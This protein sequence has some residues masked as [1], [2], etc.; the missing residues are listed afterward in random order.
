MRGLGR[1]LGSGAAI[2]LFLGGLAGAALA[3]TLPD[4][5]ALA[6]QSNPTLQSQRA[7]LRA[8]DESYVQARAGFRPQA[9]IQLQGD[10]ASGPSTFGAGVT[11]DAAAL[12]VSQPLYTGGLTS[13]QVRAAQADIQSGRQRLR[14]VEASVLQSVIQAYVDV[15]RD[16]QALGIARENVAVLLRQRD[17]TKARFDVGQI[18]RTDTAQADARLAA[19][20]AQLSA[21]QATLAISRAAYA[22]VVGQSP[23]DLAVE[24]ELSGLPPTVDQAFEGAEKDNPGVLLADYAEQAAAARVAAARSAYRPNVSLNASLGYE[25]SLTNAPLLGLRT[26]MYE[27]NITA[28]ATLTQP[29]FAGGMNASRI[30]EALENDNTQRLAVEGARRQAMQAIAQG[31]NQLLAA[32]GATTANQQQVKAD[33]IAFE[34]VRQ[35]AD[36]GLRTTLDVLN[37]EQELRNAQLALIDARHDQYVAAA[38]VLNAMGLLEIRNLD[39]NVPAYDPETSFRRVKRA[40]AVPWEGLVAGIDG[41]GAPR[42]QVR[43]ASA[44]VVL[45]PPESPAPAQAGSPVVE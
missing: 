11:T 23:G 32:R 44:P 2:G 28:A 21:A 31:W 37:A 34:G 3:D 12:S 43:P 8:L 14:Q 41:V 40:G 16:Q 19:A 36:V 29:L 33:Q 15:R 17:E 24:P 4:A 13:A 38:S 45:P 26:G 39:A 10:Y 18:T 5:I 25:G 20:Q 9:S 6:Y 30:R 1:G 7:Q 22:A 27:Q 35:E 42:V